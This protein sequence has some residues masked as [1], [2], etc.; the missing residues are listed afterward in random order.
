[1]VSDES[2]IELLIQHHLFADLGEARLARLLSSAH[3]LTLQASESLFHQGDEALRFYFVV[4]GQVRLFRMAP[5]GHEKVVDV[6]RTGHCFAEALMFGQQHQ[7]P[8]SAESL[9][10]SVVVGFENA[11]FIAELES[12][13]RLCIALMNQMSHRLHSQIIEI[14]NLSL[15]NA[16]HRLVNYLLREQESAS[17]LLVLDVPKRMLASQ[18]AIQPET[19][20]RILR[21]LS[22]ADIIKVENKRLHLLDKQKL[23]AL[24]TSNQPL[25]SA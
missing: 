13:N 18:L 22:D 17:G 2:I 6:V 20:S 1:M 24:A 12:D 16:T 11:A 15:Q 4:K 8:V 9:S 3:K 23:F 21:K 10:P 5:S 25:R 14:E 7:Y 19:L